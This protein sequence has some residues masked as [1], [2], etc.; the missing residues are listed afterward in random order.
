MPGAGWVW[1]RGH[2]QAPD[3]AGPWTRISTIQSSNQTYKQA[4][5]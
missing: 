5:P 1:E 3:I 2:A 4:A